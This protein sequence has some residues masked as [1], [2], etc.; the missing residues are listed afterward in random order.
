MPANKRE[1]PIGSDL[2]MENVEKRLQDLEDKLSLTSNALWQY[3]SEVAGNQSST[4]SQL[5]TLN[6]NVADML[7]D[8]ETLQEQVADLLA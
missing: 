7:S 8:I 4:S 6:G 5:S 1:F 3:K 2:W